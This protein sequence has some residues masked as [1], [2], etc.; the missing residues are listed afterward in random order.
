MSDLSKLTLSASSPRQPMTPLARKR[1]KLLRNLDQQIAT[2]E[3]ETRDEEFL[4]E[5]KRW[6][7]NE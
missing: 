5:V 2:A 4:Q 7:R 1:V 3:A 6:V